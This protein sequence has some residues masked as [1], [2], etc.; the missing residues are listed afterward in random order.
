MNIWPPVEERHARV[1]RL[2]RLLGY[3]NDLLLIPMFTVIILETSSTFQ[4]QESLDLFE[5]TNLGFCISFFVEWLLTL[6]LAPSRRRFLTSGSEILNLISCIPFGFLFQGARLFRLFRIVRV[7]RLAIRARRYRGR[8]RQMLQMLS[9]VGS[10]IFAGAL[11]LRI[12]EPSGSGHEHFSDALWWSIVTVSTVGY[13]DI[14]P[15]TGAGRAVASVLII[16]GVGVVGYIAGF[17]GSLLDAEEHE[18]EQAGIVRLEANILRL[19]EHLDIE[20]ILPPPDEH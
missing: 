11:A 4:Q 13:G 1:V 10:T 12:V 6:W 3:L 18:R 7:F 14:T 5:M 9:L 15:Q 19:M 16:F 2:R 20:P 8:G 17:M